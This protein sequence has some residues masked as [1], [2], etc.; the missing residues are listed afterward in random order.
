M[1][2]AGLAGL[3]LSGTAAVLAV[4]GHRRIGVRQAAAPLPSLVLTTAGPPHVLTPDPEGAGHLP[5]SHVHPVVFD[6]RTLAAWLPEWLGDAAAGPLGVDATSPGT[7]AL[8][9]AACPG[10]GLRDAGAMLAQVLVRKA[11]ADVEAL[12]RACDVVHR[13]VTAGLFP[14]G[15]GGFEVDGWAAYRGM[16]PDDPAALRAA[17]A[18]LARGG[19]AAELARELPDGVEV[20]GLGRRLEPPV[21]RGGRGSPPGVLVGPGAVLLVRQGLATLT[22]ALTDGGVEQ[23]SPPEPAAAP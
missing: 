5:G 9:R 21:L 8:V 19:T 12:R 10:A 15:A 14:L 2:E 1:V 7:Y 17:V 16:P 23:L 3:L 6:P 18:V 4:G 13:G 22:I 11:P 20:C